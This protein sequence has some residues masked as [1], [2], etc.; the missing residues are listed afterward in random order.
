[1]VRR[2]L[3]DAVGM[4]NPEYWHRDL[5]DLLVR[6]EDRGFQLEI[7]R[8]VLARRRIHSHNMSNHRSG[9]D[10]LELI[11]ITRARHARRRAAGA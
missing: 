1:M 10:H 9:A 7:L 3:F 2:S 11:A 5:Q 6:A 4:L 8:E